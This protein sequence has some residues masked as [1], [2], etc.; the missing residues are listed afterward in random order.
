MNDELL[1]SLTE[2]QQ[3]LTLRKMNYY[4]ANQEDEPIKLEKLHLS[5]A[6]KTQ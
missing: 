3:I 4:Q 5:E 6:I 2:L 1:Y